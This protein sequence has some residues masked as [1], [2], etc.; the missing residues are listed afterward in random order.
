[1]HS[2]QDLTLGCMHA[3]IEFEQ[4]TI[5]NWIYRS[6]APFKTSQNKHVCKLLNLLEREQDAQST[7]LLPCCPIS[8]CHH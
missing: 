8:S 3:C 6:E 5:K 7:S 1:M 4:K 2:V